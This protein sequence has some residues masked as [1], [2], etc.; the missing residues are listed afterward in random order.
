MTIKAKSSFQSFATLKDKLDKYKKLYYTRFG[1][2]EIV[3]MMGKD[4]RNYL[5][6][7]G[8]VKE[9]RESFTIVHPQYLIALSINLPYEKKMAP[10]IFAPY[11]KNDQLLAFL[12]QNNL[13]FHEEYESQVLFHYL[14]VFHS[15][16][17][18]DFFEKY[19][20]PKTKMFI[21]CTPKDVAEKLYGKIDYYV[22]IPSR[23]AYNSID[24]W[25]PT[26]E[27]NVSRVELVIPSA[28]A[29][30]NVIS[31][32]LWKLG[33]EVHLLDIGSIVDA[34][35]GKKSRTWIRL[36]GHK[37]EQ[38]MPKEYRDRSFSK[39]VRNLI[40][41]LKYLYRKHFK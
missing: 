7:S 21:G 18:F 25:W 26:I 38:I 32:R 8:L 34:V 20:R 13:L 1:D 11:R 14:S 5:T 17:M 37:I 24:S 3:A 28:G 31:K 27:N 6:S 16:L 29:A 33:A 40:S 41:D 9:L 36:K 30:S 10:G 2:G 22:N 19:V 35:E 12:E 15:K 23:N 4:Q 39:K